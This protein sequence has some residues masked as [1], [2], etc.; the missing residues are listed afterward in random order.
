MHCLTDKKIAL[1]LFI[2]EWEGKYTE[3]IL[4]SRLIDKGYLKHISEEDIDEQILKVVKFKREF[5]EA[6][7]EFFRMVFDNPSLSAKDCLKEVTGR[8]D[9]IRRSIAISF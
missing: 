5:R 1:E 4:M 3:A 6:A 9:Y 2:N 7:I 8:K